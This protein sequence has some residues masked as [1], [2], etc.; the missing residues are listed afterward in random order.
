ME[1][2][3]EISIEN[4]G[5]S[6][7]VEPPQPDN[8]APDRVGSLVSLG[9][10][11]VQVIE[12]SE[13]VLDFEGAKMKWARIYARGDSLWV[14]QDAFAGGALDNLTSS[15]GKVDYPRAVVLDPT[16]SWQVDIITGGSS[17]ALGL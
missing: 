3:G 1:P 11:R 9:T 8:L 10:E 12:V 5:F 2:I 6:M 16:Q 15:V 13:P 14:R 17:N 4:P 7:R